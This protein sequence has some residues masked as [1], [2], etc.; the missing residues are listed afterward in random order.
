[1]AGANLAQSDDELRAFCLEEGV[2]DRVHETLIIIFLEYGL[3]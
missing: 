3:E 1:M 2:A